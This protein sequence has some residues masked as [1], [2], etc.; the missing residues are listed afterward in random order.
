[1]PMPSSWQGGLS[2]DLAR[3]GADSLIEKTYRD[4]GSR[5]VIAGVGGVSTP[6]QAYWK[7]RHGASLVMLISALMFN[8]PQHITTLKRGLAQLLHRDGFAHVAD[9][10]GVDVE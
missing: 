5:L 1:M 8:G 2:G 6:E 7:I 4:Y 9:A 3:P 10:V